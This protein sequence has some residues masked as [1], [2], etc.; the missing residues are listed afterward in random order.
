[1]TVTDSGNPP[2]GREIVVHDEIG[3]RQFIGEV[4]ADLSWTYEAAADRGHDR[5]T[6]LTL[7]RVLQE[8]SAYLYVVQVVGRSVVYHKPTGPCHKGIGSEVG[9]L[10][11]DVL[12]WDA[13]QPCERCNPEDL[14]DYNSSDIVAVEEDLSSLYLCKDA[15]EVVNAL[16]R[17]GDMSGKRPPGQLSSLSVKLLM[18]ACRKDKEIEAAMMNTRQL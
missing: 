14:E 10:K 16:Y 12:R 7:Y 9:R 2:G 13:L 4:V 6:D 11:D 5:W 8:S 17:R 15:D 18:A 1:M 3:P